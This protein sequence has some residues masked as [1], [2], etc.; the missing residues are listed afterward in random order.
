[1]RPS[2][3]ELFGE[4]GHRLWWSNTS[5]VISAWLCS[6]TSTKGLR[7]RGWSR[8]CKSLCP[9]TCPSKLP[10]S[11]TPSNCPLPM[12]RCCKISRATCPACVGAGFCCAWR[13]RMTKAVLPLA[14]SPPSSSPR[15]RGPLSLLQQHLPHLQSLRHHPHHSRLGK[16]SSPFWTPVNLL[17]L[18]NLLHLHKLRCQQKLKRLP[19]H[20][21]CRHPIIFPH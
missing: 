14:S 12:C 15:P 17:R 18:Q 8:R 16:K 2:P 11:P 19:R 3:C 6:A 20:P 4:H 21:S 5:W 9:L 10:S 7:S 1:M 13:P